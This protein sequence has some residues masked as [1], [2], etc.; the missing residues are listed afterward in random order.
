M[1]KSRLLLSHFDY[2]GYR[3]M[4]YEWALRT[5]HKKNEYEDE[6]EDCCD[7]PGAKVLCAACPN[8]FCTA[9]RPHQPSDVSMPGLKCVI[10][11]IFASTVR[12][13]EASD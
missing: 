7:K 5:M 4:Y 3:K 10:S 8:V 9:C 13:A 1:D 12:E 2:A 6:E 11:Q